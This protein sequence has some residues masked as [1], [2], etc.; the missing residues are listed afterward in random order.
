M[1]VNH[2]LI[3]LLGL[4]VG[5]A[6]APAYADSSDSARVADIQYGNGLDPSGF[7]ALSD[8]ADPV[9]MSWLHAGSLRSPSGIPY[10]FPTLPPPEHEQ[11]AWRYSGLLSAG[12]INLSGDDDAQLFRQYSDWSNGLVLGSLWFDAYRPDSGHYA[13]LRASHLSENDQFYRFRAG[14]YGRYKIEGFYRDMPHVVSTTAYPIWNGVGTDSLTLPEGLTPGAS[15]PAAIAAAVSG[16]PRSTVRVDRT[17]TGLSVEGNV[18]KRWIGYAAVSNEERDGTRLWGGSMFFNFPFANNGGI[19]ETVRPIDF[20]TT[21][22]SVGARF[23][24]DLWQFNAVYSGSFFRNHKDSLDFESPFILSPVTG[25]PAAGVV[26]Y[27][28]FSLEPDNDAHNLRLEL[29]RRLPWNGQMSLTGAVGTMRQDE[30]LLAPV[31]CEGSIGVSGTP[32]V[33]DCANWNSSASLSQTKADARIDTLLLDAKFSFRPSAKFGWR[34][35][36][37]HYGEDNKTD[38]LAYNPLTGEYGYIS[39]NGSQ[40]SVVPGEMGIFDPNNPLYQ[41]YFAH[42][43]STPYATDKTNFDLGGDWRVNWQ[44]TLSLSFGFERREPEYRERSRVD[45]SRATLAWVSRSIANGSLRVSYEFADR[46]G[47]SYDYFPYDAFYSTSIDGF[48]EKEGANPFTVS[49]MRKYDLSDRRQ[50]KFRGIFIHPVGQAGTV[51]TILYGQYNDYSARIGRQGDRNIGLTMQ[52]DYQ[53]A[54]HFSMG[55][56]AGAEVGEMNMANVSD[57]E[58][59]VSSDADLGGDKYPLE[60]V[61]KETSQTQDLN[62][63]LNLVRDFGRTRVDAAY[64]FVYARG[65]IAYDYASL[66]AITF[67]QQAYPGEF[68]PYPDTHYRV[69]SVDL[70]ITR[71]FSQRFAARLFGRYEVGDFDDWHYLGFEDARLYDHRIYTDEGPSRHYEASLVGVMLQ[72]KL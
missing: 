63:G 53:P 8:Q 16:A 70:G 56:Y 42:I 33:A 54:P 35:E 39:E 43:R 60:N 66:G 29:S 21:D 32:F 40:G 58:G 1:T 30:T 51:S 61:W 27:G 45:E 36:L 64:S 17:R 23:V 68:S 69:H 14:R 67:N 57:N 52:W 62:F 13:D 4:G 65:E 37:R 25:T 72:F 10:G 22:L 55:V 5:I 31:T 34:A 24:G 18:A 41:S 3:A 15:D 44:N 48:V 11:G 12:V 38:Y 7:A 20:T 6:C 19:V 59:V 2:A 47:D 49:A 26:G 71:N 50:H 9:G 46:G 28:Q